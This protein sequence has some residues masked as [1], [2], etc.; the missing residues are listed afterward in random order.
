MLRLPTITRMGAKLMLRSA[1]DA[2]GLIARRSGFGLLPEGC[3]TPVAVKR[4]RESCRRYSQANASSA[5]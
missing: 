2:S 3:A 1:S 4:G 5:R